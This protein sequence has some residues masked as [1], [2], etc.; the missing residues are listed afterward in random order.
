VVV[1]CACREFAATLSRPFKLEYD[2]EREAV[3]VV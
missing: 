1:V 3:V 2:A